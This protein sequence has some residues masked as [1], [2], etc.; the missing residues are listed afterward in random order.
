MLDFGVI[1]PGNFGVYCSGQFVEH[2]SAFIYILH[3]VS[4][5]S[6]KTPLYLLGPEMTYFAQTR[7]LCTFYAPKWQTFKKGI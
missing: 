5:S 1:D 7:H 4:F 2:C 6:N 3:Q